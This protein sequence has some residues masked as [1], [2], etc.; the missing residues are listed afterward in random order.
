ME[1]P[2]VGKRA[3]TSFK[4][5]TSAAF[6]IQRRLFWS[7]NLSSGGPDGLA[8]MGREVHGSR[9]IKAAIRG[10]SCILL[11]LMLLVLLVLVPLSCSYATVVFQQRLT[12]QPWRHEAL[13]ESGSGPG[14]WVYSEGTRITLSGASFTWL[15]RIWPMSEVKVFG[16]L[17]VRSSGCARDEPAAAVGFS[18]GPVKP[19]RTMIDELH[20]S[21]WSGPTRLCSVV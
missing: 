9:V 1:S 13:G 15:A 10:W 16:S 12:S 8:K 5:V 4:S 6:V 17:G 18:S 3:K 2:F 14:S 11:L 7:R 20:P 21:N 19:V